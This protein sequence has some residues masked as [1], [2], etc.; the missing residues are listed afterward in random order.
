MEDKQW[1][2]VRALLEALPITPPA[3]CDARQIANSI[4]MARATID[5]LVQ[6]VDFGV[7][8]NAADVACDGLV[9][10]G[11]IPYATALLRAFNP[12]ERVVS[13]I[14]TLF[15]KLAT[16]NAGRTAIGGEGAVDA[17]ATIWRS[18]ISCVPVV[19][20]LVALT[21]A[22]VDNVSRA[23]RRRVISTA[24]Y[25]LKSVPLTR[26][27]RLLLEV[28]VR[29]ASMCAICTPDKPY[30]RVSLVPTLL[31]VMRNAVKA[32][33]ASIASH[34]TMALANIFDCHIKEGDGYEVGQPMVII[35]TILATWS[36]FPK[37]H[38]LGFA[39]SWAITALFN[40]DKGAQLCAE[41]CSQ[42]IGRLLTRWDAY[43]TPLF[44]RELLRVNDSP[45]SHCSTYRKDSHFSATE[46]LVLSKSTDS[47]RG[48]KEIVVQ[49]Y[50]EKHA[51]T[52]SFHNL[53][54]NNEQPFRG[55]S[56]NVM[57][58][59][60][61][62]VDSSSK[63]NGETQLPNY[64][65]DHPLQPRSRRI[66]CAGVSNVENEENTSSVSRLPD[67]DS[68]TSQLPGVR[69]RS[70]R[71]VL[72]SDEEDVDLSI[73]KKRSDSTTHDPA[74]NIKPHRNSQRLFEKG[75][76]KDRLET[77][78]TALHGSENNFELGIT[79][80]N[81]CKSDLDD[82]YE[83]DNDEGFSNGEY[84]K[85][86]KSDEDLDLPVTD[87]DRRCHDDI[88]F[89]QLLKQ[90]GSN[91]YELPSPE[92]LP[93]LCE[94]DTRMSL[95][96]SEG[97]GSD[98]EDADNTDDIPYSGRHKKP[99]PRRKSTNQATLQCPLEELR[100]RM[101]EPMSLSRMPSEHFEEVKYAS[102]IP[103]AEQT[104]VANESRR[105]AKRKAQSGMQDRAQPAKRGCSESLYAVA[106]SASQAS[107]KKPKDV[108]RRS[109]RLCADKV[110]NDSTNI[111]ILDE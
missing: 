108:H 80:L 6:A 35:E 72:Q 8:F 36:S 13:R 15:T 98:S 76:H 70:I 69:R 52:S 19:T 34:A 27:N 102:R 5:S 93:L 81:G 63:P 58:N 29:L 88:D 47:L 65:Q 30:E 3:D 12:E 94:E 68:A 22:H 11:V 18:H 28:T 33:T 41:A 87:L 101:F 99:Y 61:K 45:F 57:E 1:D 84:L 16:S 78:G 91:E 67:Y 92:L 14:A 62:F 107:G 43:S 96:A 111:I 89:S 38:D 9:E 90:D 39:A 109:A 50:H 10:A 48:N 31:S 23:M 97:N 49:T 51:S 60:E 82:Q 54:A 32:R 106:A 74:A 46:D 37:D 77:E 64:D 44:L 7:S 20:A 25:V 104:V 17:L 83:G 71:A 110:A 103:A 105:G 79:Q 100:A 75:L 4:E 40:A 55:L 95:M 66:S 56:D 53:T 42:R 2:R 26:N 85:N 59:S 24:I 21:P 86:M 73:G